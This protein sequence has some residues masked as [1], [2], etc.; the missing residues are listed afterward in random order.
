M[1][2][3]NPWTEYIDI[4][5]LPP[6]KVCTTQESSY[7][8]SHYLEGNRSRLFTLCFTVHGHG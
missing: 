6:Q 1:A 5:F 4:T 7:L 8:I 2:G 3:A